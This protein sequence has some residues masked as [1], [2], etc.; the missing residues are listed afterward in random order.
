LDCREIPILLA[1]G[2]GAQTIQ[3]TID[4]LS[5]GSLYAMFALGI[6]LIFGIV[7]L[8]N[9]AQGSI[10]MGS[11]YALLAVAGW[12]VILKLVVAIAVAV[13]LSILVDRLAFRPFRTAS[14]TTLLVTSFTLGSLF[15]A[16]AEMIDNNHPRYTDVWG[17]LDHSFVI[18]NVVIARASVITLG[19]TVLLMAILAVFLRRSRT[20]TQMRAAAENFQMARALGVR[21]NRVIAIAFVIS[22]VLAGVG[23]FLFIAQ[24]GTVQPT[25]GV[26]PLLLGFVGTVV[27]GLGSIAGAVAGGF[28]LGVLT[29]VLQSTLPSG[30]V[31]FTQ[32]FLYA[33]VFLIL[34]SRPQG[35]FGSTAGE[36][37]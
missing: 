29:E 24:A 14:P 28:L 6:S 8:V 16:V 17:W 31:P 25:I 11:A 26:T 1:S 18:G 21:S 36:R 15:Q 22:G 9:F 10:I 2:G 33:A 5:S 23:S 30:L 19:M 35:L 37:I 13:V 3:H 20:G 34:V 4:A 7:R 32:A 12:P 27:G